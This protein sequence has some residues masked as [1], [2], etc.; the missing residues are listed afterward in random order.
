MF[1]PQKEREFE[2]RF[3]SRYERPMTPEESRFLSLAEV[4][5]NDEQPTA[6]TIHLIK[7][8]EAA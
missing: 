5:L 1:G 7:K 3:L 6:P 4:A 8:D 2:A